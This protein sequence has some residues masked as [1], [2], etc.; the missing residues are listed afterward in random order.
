MKGVTEDTLSWLD[1]CEWGAQAGPGRARDGLVAR[2]ND[3]LKALRHKVDAWVPDN[4]DYWERTQGY[5]VACKQWCWF[6]DIAEEATDA[7]RR[8]QA[9]KILK[10]LSTPFTIEEVG[11]P[12]ASFTRI[13]RKTA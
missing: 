1:D 10:F 13:D 5:H 2:K 12:I 9:A 7:G 3:I 8:D 11:T 4:R 6:K